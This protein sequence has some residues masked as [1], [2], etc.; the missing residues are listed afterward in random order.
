M[1]S[2]GQAPTTSRGSI[3]SGRVTTAA[4]VGLFIAGFVGFAAWTGS[5]YQTWKAL[6]VLMAIVWVGG[7]LMIQLLALQILRSHEG[8]RIAGFAK[9][10][11]VIGMRVFVPASLI[12]VVLGFV[13]VHQ[14]HWRY[15]FWIV[16]ALV[17]WALSFV[18]GAAFLGPESGRIGRLIE[19]RGGVDG[20]V[21]MRIERLLLHSR[22]ELLLIALIAMDM[23]LKPGL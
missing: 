18:S 7:A 14:G 8:E 3:Y 4:I 2:I 23:V 21:R 10:V 22:V 9:D 19:E 16:V 1:T 15:H 11:E 12:L 17:V 13:L 6:H 20:E 5:W